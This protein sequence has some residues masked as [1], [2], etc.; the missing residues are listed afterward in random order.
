MRHLIQNCGLHEADLEPFR[1][2]MKKRL[3]EEEYSAFTLR[4]GVTHVDYEFIL[5]DKVFA[6][7]QKQLSA[8]LIG[9][10]VGD[11][12][13]MICRYFVRYHLLETPA[14]LRQDMLREIHRV[15]KAIVDQAD[16]NAYAE[17]MRT[18][19]PGE[20]E[21]EL[22]PHLLA[23]SN[24]IL[25]RKAIHY[26]L[27]HG[28]KDPEVAVGNLTSLSAMGFRPWTLSQFRRMKLMTQGDLLQLGWDELKAGKN[29][30][31]GT[32]QD[33]RSVL[34]KNNLRLKGE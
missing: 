11:F 7:T 34:E 32:L 10:S 20:R 12:C 3:S 15:L 33:I 18:L 9:G 21:V 23:V 13:A 14:Y 17:M 29:M 28:I 30:G 27:M 19:C 22:T 26:V 2:E 4:P 5:D 1:N 16:E 8:A 25:E 24:K 6:A 31:I